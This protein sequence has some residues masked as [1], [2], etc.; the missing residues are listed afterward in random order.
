[1]REAPAVDDESRESS[2]ESGGD[3]VDDESLSS[4]TTMVIG[5][6]T[7]GAGVEGGERLFSVRRTVLA[8][9]DFLKA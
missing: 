3:F 1:M 9:K 4:L 8:E 6:M 5:G 2:S 7:K